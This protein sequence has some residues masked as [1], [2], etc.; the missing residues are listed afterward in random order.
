MKTLG[1]VARIGPD[2][3]V[4]YYFSLVEIWHEQTKDGT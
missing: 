1:I 2:S 3:T 4:D